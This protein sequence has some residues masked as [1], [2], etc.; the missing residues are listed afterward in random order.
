MAIYNAQTFKD[1]RVFCCKTGQYARP[2]KYQR[3]SLSSRLK[4]AWLVFTGKCDTLSW[5]PVSTDSQRKAPSSTR[6]HPTR[7]IITQF[8]D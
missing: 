7:R 5:E 8:I 2:I 3:D 4:Q 1:F 6:Q